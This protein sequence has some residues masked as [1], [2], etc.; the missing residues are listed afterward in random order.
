MTRLVALSGNTLAFGAY[1]TDREKI[2]FLR[3]YV[4]GIGHTDGTPFEAAT[5]TLGSGRSFDIY[6]MEEIQGLLKQL[7]VVAVTGAPS[8]CD[9]FVYQWLK[10]HN[11]IDAFGYL[12]DKLNENCI[13]N[14]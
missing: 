13:D 8:P 6:S 4:C 7:S 14:G 9:I 3:A 1:M 10:A 2:Q 5:L 12:E 11:I